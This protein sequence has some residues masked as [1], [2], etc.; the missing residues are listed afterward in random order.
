MFSTFKTSHSTEETSLIKNHG[1]TD[2]L[3]IM[4]LDIDK[5]T[6]PKLISTLAGMDMATSRIKVYRERLSG[7]KSRID[8]DAK[9]L[10]HK[11]EFAE[12]RLNTL[13][14]KRKYLKS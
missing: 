13:N 8:N 4:N 2:A 5:I 6:N 7:E 14:E 9:T 10:C 3:S 12:K 11:K 1:V